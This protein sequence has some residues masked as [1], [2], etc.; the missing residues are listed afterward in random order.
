[1]ETAVP[2]SEALGREVP[3]D[4]SVMRLAH[5]VRCVAAEPEFAL[6]FRKVLPP[7]AVAA[8]EQ[9]FAQPERM[10]SDIVA[11]VIHKPE[12]KTLSELVSATSLL[13]GGSELGNVY[14]NL[15]L[16]RHHAAAQPYFRID[17]ALCT[18]LHATD[19]DDDIPMDAVKVPYP[20]FFIEFGTRRDLPL[21]ILNDLSGKHVLEGAYLEAGSRGVDEPGIYVMLTG[22]PVGKRNALDDAVQAIFLPT[23]KGLTLKQALQW[24]F[25]EGR[26]LSEQQGLFASD[27]ASQAPALECLNFLAKVLLYIGLPEARRSVHPERTHWEKS[28]AGL[29]STAKVA[30]AQRKARL[31]ADYILITASAE[32]QH[33]ATELDREGRSVRSHWRRG[34]YRMQAYGAQMSLRKL[35]FISPVLVNAAQMA[36][37]TAPQYHVR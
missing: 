7:K 16:W 25:E 34:H 37:T 23:G 36:A 15:L 13:P 6:G 12:F 11:S 32:T 33:T 26:L 10:T 28:H 18:M 35:V 1:M 9:A 22:S 5:P 4:F 8:I 31:L 3:A 21:H 29:K 20:R 14:A 17:D 24:S 30:K 19:L 27:P 2:L